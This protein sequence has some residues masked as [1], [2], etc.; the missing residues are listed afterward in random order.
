METSKKTFASEARIG[1]G[2]LPNPSAQKQQ[3]VR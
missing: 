2:I 1:C 3:F